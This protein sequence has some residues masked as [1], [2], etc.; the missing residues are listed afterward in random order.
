VLHAYSPEDCAKLV[1]L[2]RELCE[3]YPKSLACH[4]MP[5]D[6]LVSDASCNGVQW[7][8]EGSQS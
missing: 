8:L 7:L 1:A 6:F 2:Y 3:A 5:L 4:R